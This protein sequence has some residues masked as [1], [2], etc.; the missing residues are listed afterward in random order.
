MGVIFCV[1]GGGTPKEN[2]IA[3]EAFLIMHDSTMQPK[4]VAAVTL[5]KKQRQ[6]V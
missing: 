3:L 1:P 2:K 6:L 5:A 4:I